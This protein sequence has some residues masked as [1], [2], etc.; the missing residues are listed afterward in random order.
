[1]L[2]TVTTRANGAQAQIVIRDTGP[3]IPEELQDRIFKPFFTTRAKGTGL[4]LAIV[5]NL[6]QA[7]GGSIDAVSI[8]ESG[9]EFTVTLPRKSRTP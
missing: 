6:V 5:R 9:A 8:P 1:M 2:L 7:H 3:G 4:G